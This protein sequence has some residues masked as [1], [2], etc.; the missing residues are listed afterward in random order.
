MGYKQLD[1]RKR[2]QIYGLWRA[3]H[4]QIEIAQEIGVHKSTISRELKR[5]ITFVRTALGSWQYKPNYA[6]TYAE[7]RRKNKS[8]CI[9]FTENV[10]VFVRDKLLQ[11]WSPEQIS[12]YAKRHHLF[13]ISHERIY[14]FILA[15]KQK[16][17]NLYKYLRH[18]NKKY[19]KRYGSPKRH[20][21]IKN[22]TMIDERP[23]IVDEKRRLGDWEIDT[24]VGPQHQKAIVTLVER[25]SKKTLIGKVGTKRADFV[26]DQTILLLSAIQSSVL[27]ITAD[28]GSEFAQHERIAKALGAMIYFA[29]PY[30][31]WERGLNE[32]TNGLIRQYIPKGK[33]LS[34]VT[35]SDI[36][37]IQ[38]RLNN[39]PRKLLNYET[40]NEVF[41]RMQKSA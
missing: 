23:A 16:G 24:I 19:R 10:E 18:Q 9:K 35:D 34:A 27:T 40:P 41:L 37:R 2:C 39:R 3:G 26:G 1:F 25:V 14:Q 4:T 31:S 32:N 13:W 28:N 22:R 5:N 21:P 30:H 20:S 38:E 36:L 33:D 8:K 7:K 12:G 29:H 15:D 17:G 11:E 6:Q